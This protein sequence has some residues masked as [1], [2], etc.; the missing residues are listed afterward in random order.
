MISSALA[1]ALDDKFLHAP[2]LLC[3]LSDEGR[4]E[5]VNAVM[6][7]G[8]AKV[9]GDL[10]G[11]LLGSLCEPADSRR[12]REELSALPPDGC[13][14]QVDLPMRMNGG[15]RWISWVLRRVETRIF[16]SG[17]DVT[18]SRLIE[19]TA[20][21][22]QVQARIGGWIL[23]V[24]DGT[25]TWTDILYEIH[26]VPLGTPTNLIDGLSYYHPDDRP[27][28]S[29]HLEAAVRERR[30]F[31]DEF[32]FRT[33]DG[34]ELWIRSTGV[35]KLADSGEV[36]EIRGT[37]QDI[38]SL[39]RAEFESKDTVSKLSHLLRNAPG[40]VYQFRMAP[41]GKMYFPYASA[42]TF[43][44]YGIEPEDF[45]AN[46]SLMLDMVHTDDK[47]GLR[48]AIEASART[49]TPFH[50]QGRIETKAG[51]VKWIRANSIPVAQ[52]DGSILWDG[53]V[54]DVSREVTLQR[55]VDEQR[56]L[57]EQAA[58][59]AAIGELAAGV[60]HEINNPLAIACAVTANIEARLAAESP[61]NPELARLFRKNEAALERIRGIV[62]GLANFI[63]DRAHGDRVADLNEALATTVDLVREV[64][65]SDQIEIALDL[66][67]APLLV[68]CN[69]S[70]LQQV[71]MNL[72]SN[73]RDA[74][75]GVPRGRIALSSRLDGDRATAAI[76]DNGHG[77]ADENR[78]KIFST[79]FTTKPRGEGTGL[80]LALSRNIVSASGGRVSFESTLGVGTTFLVSLPL[81]PE[82]EPSPALQ[83]E[84]APKAT[85]AQ[86]SRPSVLVVDDEPD[87]REILCDQL[88]A[89]G[90][91]AVAAENGRHA[92]EILAHR[93][94]DL[95]FTD[96]KM[97]E[98]GGVELV[99]RVREELRHSRMTFVAGTGASMLDP[100]ASLELFAHVL[101]KP[102]GLEELQR[103]VVGLLSR[104]E[105]AR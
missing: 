63:V 32:R 33:R 82:A 56:Q 84:P 5:H 8:F 71:I 47:D 95:L 1:D 27:R 52:T 78:S 48:L 60:G 3:V 19:S 36:M 88:G 86:A 35:P 40:M 7:D 94:F 69:I 91:E 49:M 22:I 68:S 70:Q 46:P 101:T 6:R 37:F 44:I 98:M 4:L 10:R 87:L 43:E 20:R 53:I 102:Y 57:A 89:A 96:L 79:F 39:K 85:R 105:R 103:I 45:R 90:L 41:D 76:E 30:P 64:I 55:Q 67:P 25:T 74:T 80:G 15:Q 17:R 9:A 2:D 23:N 18:A 12:F 92:L 93:T 42:K 51:V 59:M 61:V 100:A 24:A 50:W 99:R 75:K 83:P 38:T 62:R 81:A 72:I 34:L 97:P 13:A 65:R 77:I 29:A 11:Q 104:S 14:R 21:E 31:D 58:K 26:G 54:I 73:A 28:L 16:G 66:H